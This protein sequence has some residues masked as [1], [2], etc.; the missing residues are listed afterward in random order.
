MVDFPAG[1]PLGNATTSATEGPMRPFV[2]TALKRRRNN[3]KFSPLQA[4]LWGE[5]RTGFPR[6]WP[7]AEKQMS[8]AFKCLP[9]GT[10]LGPLSE[11]GSIPL[12]TSLRASAA[13]RAPALAESARATFPSSPALPSNPFA[14]N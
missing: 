13:R 6:P 9:L 10:D 2:F 7:V 4:T 8:A 5:P 1:T 11:P 3:S 14:R 12:Q